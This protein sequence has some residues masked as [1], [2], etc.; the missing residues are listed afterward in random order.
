MALR[1]FFSRVSMLKLLT[2]FCML[3]T[4]LLNTIFAMPASYA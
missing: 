3:P 2:I 1:H 4:T